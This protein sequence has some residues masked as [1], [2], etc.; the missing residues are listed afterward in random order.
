MNKKII[1][2][3]PIIIILVSLYILNVNQIDE[4][5]LASTFE[6]SA[7]YFDDSHVV[8]IS[9]LDRSNHT[10]TVILEIDGLSQPFQKKYDNSS[11]VEDIPIYSTPQYGWKTTP[12]TL[13]IDHNE[14]GK[15]ILKTEIIPY[16]QP[17]SKVIY[18]RP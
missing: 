5:R 10:N 15:I 14:F 13:L 7:I 4:K 18:G 9:Y 8:K 17:S 3:V 6:F 11:F 1:I 16:G 2:T 12:V